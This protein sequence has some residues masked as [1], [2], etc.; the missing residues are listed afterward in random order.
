ME[1]LRKDGEAL[2]EVRLGAATALEAAREAQPLE[3]VDV[4]E[5]LERAIQFERVLAPEQ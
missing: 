2:L 4:V 1:S 5:D 3:H